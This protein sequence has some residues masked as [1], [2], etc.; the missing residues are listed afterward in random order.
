MLQ[1]GQLIGNARQRD[2]GFYGESGAG[3]GGSKI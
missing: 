2:P 1:R 3:A